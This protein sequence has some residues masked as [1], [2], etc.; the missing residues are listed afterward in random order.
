MTMLTQWK[1]G[2]ETDTQCQFQKFKIIATYIYSPL[3]LQIIGRLNYLPC[4]SSLDLMNFIEKYT[5]IL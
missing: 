4:K 1:L 5:N 3:F 2:W